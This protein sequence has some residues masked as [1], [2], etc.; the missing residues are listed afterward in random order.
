MVERSKVVEA[1]RARIV[2]I[3]PEAAAAQPGEDQDLREFSGFDSLGIL[4]LLVWLEGE[5]AIS[6]PDEELV[7]SN[8]S[9]I[10]K[11]ADYVVAHQ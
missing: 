1:V 10:G 3:V 9:C 2:D 7:V 6:I 4:E 8:F 11:M 5:F